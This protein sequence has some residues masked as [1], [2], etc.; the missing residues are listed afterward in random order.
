M[1]VLVRWFEPGLRLRTGG[2]AA[3]N[4]TCPIGCRATPFEGRPISVR[5]G[6]KADIGQSWIRN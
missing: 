4:G 1:E 6:W 3:G 2:A 5:N